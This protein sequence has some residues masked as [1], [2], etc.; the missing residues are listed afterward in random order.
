MRLSSSFKRLTYLTHRWTGVFGCLLMSLWFISGITMLFVGYPKL[1]PDERLAA[2]PPLSLLACCTPVQQ[3]WLEDGNVVLSTVGGQASY[4]LPPGAHAGP[5][6]LRARDGQPAE[7]DKASVLQSARQFLPGVG[8]RYLGQVGEDRWTHARGLDPHRPL[9]VVEMADEQ[10]T[11]LYLSSQTGQVVLD[12]PLSQRRW[13]YAGAWLHWLYMFR[14]TSIDPVWHWLLVALSALGTLT[15]LSGILAGLW[16]WRFTNRYKSG[17]RSPYR[18]R[19]AYWHHLLGLLFAGILFTWI[20]SGLASM[21]PLQVFSPRHEA[22]DTRAFQ[23]AGEV[24]DLLRH[25]AP[26]LIALVRAGFHASELEWRRLNGRSYVL[27]RSADNRTRILVEENARLVVLERLPDRWL[28]AGAARLLPHP[29]VQQEWLT[30]YDT[31]YYAR[32]PEAMNGAA[33]RRLPVWKLSFADPDRT[34]VYLDAYSGDIALAADARQRTGRWWFNLLHSW[35]LP[36]MLSWP[37]S[38]LVVLILL[39]LGGLGIC[40]SA[41]VIAWRR[42]RLT[43]RR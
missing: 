2:L 10:R 30:R 8:A 17:S 40:L 24:P 11:R 23:G 21:N 16:R 19:W 20:L 37:L 29:V 32:Q 12:A 5:Q 7:R 31:H 14:H 34:W 6:R 25:P 9:H 28:L 27:A 13:N 36:G 15:A 38:R 3:A 43:F 26:M 41:S 4:L 18:A 22:L 1:T 33:Q 42:L 35:D 39:S